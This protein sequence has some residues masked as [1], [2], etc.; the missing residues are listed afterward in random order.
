MK[1]LIGNLL[2]HI[3]IV[4]Y[5][6]T[7]MFLYPF[8]YFLLRRLRNIKYDNSVLHISYMVHT[9][10]NTVRILR[11]QG[12]K[13]DYLALGTGKV[14]D[15]CDFQLPNL[16]WPPIQALRDFIFFWKVVAK[17][18]IIHL[19]F[20]MPM[21]KSGW[22][23]PIL[24]K[25]GRKIV[26]HYRGCEIR[27]RE[28]NIALHPE[29]NI[30]QECDYHPFVV[31]K[32][33]LNQRRR[34]LARKYGDLFLITT[35]DLKDFAPDAE[36]FPFFAPEISLQDFSSQANNDPLKG[37]VKIVHVTVHPGIEGTKYI[38]AAINRLRNKGYKI[39][40]V[41]LSRVSHDRV[42]AE[43]KDA[44]LAIGKMKMGYYANAQIE[45]MALGIPTI[46]YIRPE[47]I[48]NELENSGFILTTLKELEKTLEYYLTHP[49]KLEKKRKIARA[50]ILRLHNNE[51]LGRKLVELYA[52]IKS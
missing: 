17:Y 29:V 15:K 14:W 46:T 7:L 37:E 21:S 28:K 9:A 8:N 31:C 48:T 19:H 26:I 45:S 23:L 20:A 44:N 1:R 2:H 43:Y 36:H 18:E 50:S 33:V 24:K 6:W 47:F 27:N 30:C 41:F 40:F 13:A 38:E 52:S 25:M 49:E 10:Y 32:R 11:E 42:L 4:V 34:R 5:Q 12:M 3:W 16:Y 22:E 39:N 35:P 51:Q